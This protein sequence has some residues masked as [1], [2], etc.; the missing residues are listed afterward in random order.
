MARIFTRQELYNLVWATPVWELAKGFDISDRGLAKICAR[1]DIPVP[2][3]GYWAKKDAGKKVEQKALPPR[4]LGK[5]D[6]V[7][8]GGHRVYSSYWWNSQLPDNLSDEEIRTKTIPARPVF[9][10][11]LQTVREKIARI[12]AKAQFPK[13][14]IKPHRFVEK[15]LAEDEERLRKNQASGILSYSDKPRFD[16][17]IEHRRLKIINTLYTALETSGFQP[18][19]P[20]SYSRTLGVKIGDQEVHFTLEETTIKKGQFYQETSDNKRSVKTHI[21]FQISGHRISDDIQTVWEDK[22][23]DKL[24]KQASAIVTELIAAGEVFS[25]IAQIERYERGVKRKAELEKKEQERI[26][27]EARKAEERRRRQE[28]A[29]VDGLLSQAAA[30]RQATEIRAYVEAVQL[31]NK[32]D[33]NPKTDEE[34]TIWVKWAL[35]RA[36]NIDPVKSGIYKTLDEDDK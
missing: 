4:G 20:P 9:N 29:R 30:F 12:I 13:K 2:Q 33:P 27:E 3:R 10:E 36:D 15:L 19:T 26:L 1:A 21:R 11:D 28:Q 5:D 6:E 23:N 34:L 24:E 16:S 22:E 8:I 35:M 32:T 17:P 14:L 25:R 31:A 18:L 7:S